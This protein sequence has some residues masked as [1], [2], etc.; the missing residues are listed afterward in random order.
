VECVLTVAN[1]LPWPAWGLVVEGGFSAHDESEYGLPDAGNRTNVAVALAHVPGFSKSDYQW[2]FD[3]PC[4]GEYPMVNPK[5][6]TGFP[7]G[8]WKGQR[9]IAVESRLLVWPRAVRLDALPLTQGGSWTVG[10]LSERR[11]GYEGDVIGTRAFRPGDLLRHVHWPQTARQGQMIVCERQAS[12]TSSVRVVIDGYT[13]H[14]SSTGSESTL[15]WTLRI[16]A[17]ICEALLNHDA[18]LTVELGG[19]SLAVEPGPSGHQRLNDALA[20]FQLPRAGCR[21]VVPRRSR[22]QKRKQAD[23][24]EIV[25]TTGRGARQWATFSSGDRRLVV[26]DAIDEFYTSAPA[27]IELDSEDDVLEQLRHQWERLSRDD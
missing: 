12:L 22:S 9:P 4:R 10:T 13:D 21:T 7:F 3:P 23:E 1:R 20:R 16:A 2:D 18:Q 5:L 17:S 6:T 14:H 15:E 26:L 8:L 24:I 19:E 11:W 27:W 25:I